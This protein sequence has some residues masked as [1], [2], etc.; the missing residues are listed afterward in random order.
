MHLAAKAD[1]PY[2]ITFLK[3]KGLDVD[4]IDNDG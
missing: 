4:C 3:K 2:P 1:L